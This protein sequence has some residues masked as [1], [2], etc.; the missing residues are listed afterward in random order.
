M[1]KWLKD[2]LELNGISEDA[3]TYVD[4]YLE[5]NKQHHFWHGGKVLEFKYKDVFVSIEAIGD[6]RA[7]LV[8][9]EKDASIVDVKDKY[10]TGEFGR[11]L[12]FYVKDD[13]ELDLI[14][15]ENHPKYHLE[16]DNNN[17]WECFLIK[18]DN[19]ETDFYD[20]M[21]DL[22]D[23]HLKDALAEV[24]EGIDEVHKGIFK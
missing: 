21:W 9:T 18:R 1:E 17:W 2:L 10:N 13:T 19:Q 3:V 7:Q 5:E 23:L 6:V 8:I 20:L 24:M 16:V 11:E 4:G 12:A 14:E 22:G 15:N